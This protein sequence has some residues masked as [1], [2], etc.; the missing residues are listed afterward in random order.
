MAVTHGHGN[1]KWTRDEVI[2]ALDL[3]FECNG[4]IPSSKDQRVIEL[5]HL[6]RSFPQHLASARK[7]TFRNADGVAFKL[8][9]L[10][11]LATGRGLG[12]TSKMD[13]E[14]WTEFGKD[15]AR[16]KVLANLIRTG[17]KVV[18]M[19]EDFNIEKETFYEGRIVTEAHLRRERNPKIRARLLAQR[20]K[21]GPLSC[22]ICDCQS[23]ATSEEIAM[24]MFEVHH[25]H[26]LSDKGESVTALADLALL[27]ANCH[28]MVH[29]AIAKGKR[30]I[31]ILEARTFIFEK[32]GSSDVKLL[33]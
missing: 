24:A 12:N 14:V 5:S 17:L 29:K 18:E 21:M 19:E 13:N 22:D 32:T 23:L 26:P 7:K 2:L 15:P 25:I 30:W 27:C 8:Q 10:R 1:P 11:Q 4:N 16:T 3:Y 6:L 28:R 20:L 33:K 31:S 9:N